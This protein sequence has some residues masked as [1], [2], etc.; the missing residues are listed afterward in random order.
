MNGVETVD[1]WVM[2]YVQCKNCMSCGLKNLMELSL[3]AAGSSALENFLEHHGD[4]AVIVR[5]SV[6]NSF[7]VVRSWVVH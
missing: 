5:S 3:V 1:Y 7:L 4:A 6:D 2:S